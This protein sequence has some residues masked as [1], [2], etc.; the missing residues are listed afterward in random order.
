MTKMPKRR[1]SKDNPYTLGYDDYRQIY[2]ISFKDINNVLQTIEIDELLYNEFNK[3]ELED[4]SQ[5][6][7]FDNHIEHLEISD[8]MLY[9]KAFIKQSSIEEIVEEKIQIEQLK[10]NINELPLIQ[11]KRL[12]KYY[13]EGKN[14]EDIAQEENCTKR[15]IKFSVD[16]A[17]KKIS[18]K[19]KK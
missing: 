13:F 11:R 3:F 8:E 2:T 10:K 18:Q 14:F 7:K 15:A 16:I 9:K 5:M 6:N 1:K 12:K 19:M 17:I 4:I